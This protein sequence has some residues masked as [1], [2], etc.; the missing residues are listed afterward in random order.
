MA[1]TRGRKFW[2][3]FAAAWL[4]L[5]ATYFMAFSMQGRTSA[6]KTFVFAL[7]NVLPDALLGIGIA[8]MSNWVWRTESSRR[9]AS[10]LIAMGL[11][12]VVASTASKVV[13]D[14][15]IA[16]LD[17]IDRLWSS[18]DRGV[19]TWQCF[20]SLLAFV[21][22][23]SVTFSLTAASRLR[24]EEARRSEA[25]LLR[26]RSELKALRAQLNPHL[27]FNTLHSVRALIAENPIAAEEA[28]EHLGDLLRYALRV[29]DATDE[30][31]LLREEWEFVRVYLSLEELR[32]GERLRVDAHVD[33]AA[34]DSIV[35]AF[36]LQP[37]VEN[38]IRHGIA[39][40]ERGGTLRIRAEV[41]SG[42]LTLRVDN[43][44]VQANG[45]GTAAL[46]TPTTGTGRG[47]DL[48]RQRLR[49]L[50]GAASTVDVDRSSEAGF[51]VTLRF[52]A[53]MESW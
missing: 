14:M 23:M 15:L 24:E 5:L 46:H 4:P 31:V 6:P 10:L 33:E 37:L 9:R 11:A 29:Q 32:L 18:Y 48:V 51:S 40:L 34:L 49:A 16:N 35:P 28:L 19:L 53:A 50:Y 41:E 47:L 21:V 2:S 25:D 26:A 22:I 36:V 43:D 7:A 13:L 38:A 52:P 45:D 30:G 42:A 3:W 12:F 17:G 27:L 39:A 1:F 20:I 8:C 44:I